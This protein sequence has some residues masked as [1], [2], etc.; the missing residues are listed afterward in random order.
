MIEKELILSLTESFALIRNKGD[1]LLFNRTTTQMK[2][3]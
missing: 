3:K 1:Q 2:E